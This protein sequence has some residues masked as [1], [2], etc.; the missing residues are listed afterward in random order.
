[1]EAATFAANAPIELGLRRRRRSWPASARR[2]PTPSRAPRRS[3]TPA[4]STR[5]PASWRPARATSG[6]RSR[7]LDLLAWLHLEVLE[8]DDVCFSSKGHDAPAVYA[9]LAGTGKLDVR[10]AAPPAAARRAPGPS[11]RPRRAGR[12]HQHGL[13]RHGRLEGQGHRARGAARGPAPA[14]VRHHRRRR[15]AG[16]P[17]LGVARAGRQ[18][19]LRRAARDRRPQQD[20]VR[21]LG[22]ARSARSATWRPRCARSAGRSRAATATTSA[23]GRGDARRAARATRRRPS[24]WSPTRSRAAACARFE[25]HELER[26]GTALYAYHS[27]APA[28]DAYDGGAGRAAGRLE[29]RLG[30]RRSSWSRPGAAPRRAGRRRCGSSPPTAT[31]WPRPRGARAASRRPRRRPL[32]GLRADPVPRA[33][34]RALRR[35]RHRRAGHGLPG[36]RRW[37]S[38][39]RCPPCTR[40]P[41]SS[42]RGPTSRSSTT[43]PRARG[44]STRA[45]WPGSCPAARATR[46]SPCATSR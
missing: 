21:H 33:L 5:S 41:A 9:V 6:R 18:R 34:P 24:C 2:S 28:P 36:R 42:P 25:P 7:V 35:V 39:A 4:G 16:G 13:A 32:P 10:P 29:E 31:R 26:A 22:R 3:P 19:G 23:R 46:T 44:S 11:R 38:A 15:A 27:G 40:S 45:S 30:R 8:G 14:R 17:V 20:P 12:A 43:R 1:M 37:R